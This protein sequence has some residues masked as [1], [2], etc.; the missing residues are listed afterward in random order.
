[1][2]RFMITGVIL[3][4]AFTA[5]VT[6]AGGHGGSDHGKS[7][8]SAHKSQ[9]SIVDI[10]LSNE[11]FSTLVTALKKADLVGALQ[12]DG[13]FTVFAPTNDAFAKLPAG[14]LEDLLKPENKEKLQ[15]VL[16]YHVVAAKVPASAAV[17]NKTSLDTLAGK[18]IAVDGTG[19]GVKVEN[20][21]VVKT[22]IMG[23]NG[24]IHVI[25]TVLIP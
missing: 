25:D 2:K 13:P 15:K 4:T 1:M 19:K 17:N 24:I 21:N 14:M 10:A 5:L 3:F 11:D 12:G 22:D 6:Q 7:H 20:A 9:N 16:K 18:K 23:S 8:D